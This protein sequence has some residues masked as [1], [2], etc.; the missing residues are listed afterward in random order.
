MDFPQMV[1]NHA[2]AT[3]LEQKTTIATKQLVNVTASQTLTEESVIN[4]K[5]DIGTSL[6]VNHVI[7]MDMLSLATQ[8]LES[9]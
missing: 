7:V 2:I 3:A 4:V 6:T 8:E 1:A 9:A 5:L